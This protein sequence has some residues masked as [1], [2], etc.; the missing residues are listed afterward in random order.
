MMVPGSPLPSPVQ[1]VP[2]IMPPAIVGRPVARAPSLPALTPLVELRPYLA[3]HPEMLGLVKARHSSIRTRR[4]SLLGR[5]FASWEETTL[6]LDQAKREIQEDPGLGQVLHRE[7]AFFQRRANAK[8]HL[9]AIRIITEAA[10]EEAEEM[11]AHI[12]PLPSRHI[13]RWAERAAELSGSLTAAR[14]GCLKDARPR[15]LGPEDFLP[16]LGPS[17][18]LKIGW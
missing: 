7:L 9:L 3:M 5:A 8:L 2:R 18:V 10:P 15:L 6:E 4:A 1:S 13:L 17:T 12:C 14:W 16:R 11:G